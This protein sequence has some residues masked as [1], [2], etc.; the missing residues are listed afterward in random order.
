MH[1]ALKQR[2]TINKKLR[3]GG[4]RGGAFL[5]AAKSTAKQ[6]TDAIPNLCGRGAPLVTMRGGR[7]G[8]AGEWNGG[9]DP[10][11]GSR[12]EEEESGWPGPPG[13]TRF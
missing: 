1:Q 6:I 5:S 11:H 9:K 13:V 2:R 3:G 8:G 7:C 4:G 12:E 10:V